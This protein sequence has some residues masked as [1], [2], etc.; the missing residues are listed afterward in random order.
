MSPTSHDG[1][2]PGPELGGDGWQP[3]EITIATRDGDRTVPALVHQRHPY[4][5]IHLAA[6]D[7]W[8]WNVTH[9]PTGLAVAALYESFI[10]AFGALAT[11]ARI[12]RRVDWGIADPFRLGE[13]VGE[14]TL[15]LTPADRAELR[16]IQ[17][18]GPRRVAAEDAYNLILGQLERA[19]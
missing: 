12:F 1:F 9:V 18:T 6:R 10:G 16:R 17:C 7:A 14:A 11:V 8:S 19:S 13:A 2:R 3:T 4:F 15:H 5:A